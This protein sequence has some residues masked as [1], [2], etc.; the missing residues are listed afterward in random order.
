MAKKETALA[1][2]PSEEKLA[3]LRN[4][5]PEDPGFQSKQLP[6]I[7]LISQDV[8]EQGR[9]K[10]GKKVMKV[11]T[12]AGEFFL[13]VQD[14]E[15]TK[16]EDGSKKKLWNKT[17][18]GT[19]IEVIFAFQ[20]KQLKHYDGQSYT[21][22]DV[23]DSVNDV[24]RLWKD[25]AEIDSGT[26]KEL[27]GRKQYQGLSAKGKPM[28]KLEEN[29]VL[30]VLY[31]ESEDDEYQLYQMNLRGT[32]YYAFKDFKKANAVS[33][34]VTSLDSEPKKNGSTEWN[35]MTFEVVRDI[36]DAEADRVIAEVTELQ[37]TV[38]RIKEFRAA[39]AQ[40]DD[41]FENYGKDKED[42]ISDDDLPFR[43]DKPQRVRAVARPVQR[44]L[45][46][47]RKG[48]KA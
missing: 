23:Y 1:K 16:L 21:S 43:D 32:S 17:F 3:L 41:E 38:E 34:I 7:G 36:N 25:G 10:Q 13:D 27:Q 30:Y 33:T 44:A 37:E 22:S 18:L 5:F 14:E 6:R 47:G 45:P 26:V 2:R 39:K 9:D 4:S 19:T 35:Q 12:D 48:R 29:G 46:A 31:R 24:I 20:R 8:V 11:V 15:E 28:S 42:E 40:G